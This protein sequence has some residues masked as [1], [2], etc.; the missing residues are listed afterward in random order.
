MEVSSSPR[1]LFGQTPRVEK[2]LSKPVKTGFG[3]SKIAV[4]DPQNLVLQGV[5]KQY[6]ASELLGRPKYPWLGGGLDFETSS[7]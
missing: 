2:N 6:I 3:R 4:F 1:G 5:T 7:G